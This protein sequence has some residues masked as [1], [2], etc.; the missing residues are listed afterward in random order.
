MIT[1]A[2][3]FVIGMIT[4]LALVV[5]FSGTAH[6]EPTSAH[7]LAYPL[8]D[9]RYCGAPP[10]N[11]DGTIKRS[12]AVK[13]AFRKAHPC[14]STGKTTGACPGQSI[15]HVIPLE[16]GGCDSVTNM[17]WLPNAIKSCALSSGVPCK[18]RWER[19]IYADPF[20]MP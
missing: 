13:A 11:A 15:D 16:N 19:K 18:D 20:V 4:A 10:R 2:M 1:K 7:P 6:A 8:E 12:A 14:P 17:Q 5:L 9:Q 3:C